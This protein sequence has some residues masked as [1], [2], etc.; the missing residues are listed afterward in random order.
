MNFFFI[1]IVLKCILNYKMNL[2]VIINFF[3]KFSCKNI[4]GGKNP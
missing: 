2:Y 3:V 4:T 1:N